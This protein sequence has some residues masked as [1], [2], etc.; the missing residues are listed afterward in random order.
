VSNHAQQNRVTV[1]VAGSDGARGVKAE[2]GQELSALRA[3]A[4]RRLGNPEHRRLW[5]RPQRATER[6]EPLPKSS[7]G[8]L[9][10]PAHFARTHV[11]VGE[12]RYGAQGRSE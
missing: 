5:L 12:R 11:G 4:G 6:G 7:F 8:Q 2:V 1:G 10:H 9:E 3:E